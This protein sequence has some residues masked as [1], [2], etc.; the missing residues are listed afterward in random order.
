MRE[1]VDARRAA[2]RQYCGDEAMRE[3]YSVVTGFGR[4]ES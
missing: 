4:T 2:R 3:K 1:H